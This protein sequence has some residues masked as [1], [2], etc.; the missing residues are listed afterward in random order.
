MKLLFS[1]WGYDQGGVASAFNVLAPYLESLGHEVRVVL[2]SARGVHDDWVSIRQKYVVGWLPPFRSP[3]PKFGWL[4]LWVNCLL[5]WRPFFW[6]VPHTFHNLEYDVFIMFHGQESIWSC[7]N[8]RPCVFWFHEMASDITTVGNSSRVLKWSKSRAILGYDRFVAVS[9]NSAKSLMEY[10]S[11]SRMPI[12]I[13]NLIDVEMVEQMSLEPQYEIVD[14]ECRNI[15]YVGRL[16]KEKGVDRLLS[17]F[18]RVYGVDRRIRL[19]IIGSVCNNE[20]VNEL[21]DIVNSHGLTD[22]VVFLGGKANPYP[23]MRAADLLVLPSR[24]EGLGLV[25][26]ESLL[27]NT[28]VMATRCGGTE[29]ALLNGEIGML[30]E[31]STAGIT[32]GLLEYLGQKHSYDIGAAKNMV[33][34]RIEESKN[35]IK[36]LLSELKEIYVHQGS[37]KRSLVK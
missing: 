1:I 3:I 28:P 4:W 23:Y 16:A 11:L 32:A 26:W 24:E 31:N 30:V 34:R 8:R 5:K 10:F 12:V 17:A 21:Y 18:A 25:L 2:S 35:R 6:C 22:S 33:L 36:N 7:F 27:C 20:Y 9:E 15:I 19:W 14:R 13:R 29:D 37:E